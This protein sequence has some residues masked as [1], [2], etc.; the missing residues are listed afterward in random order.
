VTFGPE[1][2]IQANDPIL[3][4]AAV[5]GASNH[6]TDVAIA[7]FHVNRLIACLRFL[8]AELFGRRRQHDTDQ[9]N[10]QCRGAA[11]GHGPT[12]PSSARLFLFVCSTF[13]IRKMARDYLLDAVLARIGGRSR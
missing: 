4:A 12:P 6:I 7:V 11:I 9:I 2:I 13:F 8:S 5:V 10:G 3:A 1:K